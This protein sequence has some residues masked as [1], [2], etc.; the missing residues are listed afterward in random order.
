[1]LVAS[2]LCLAAASA[3]LALVVANG[4]LPSAV[5]NAVF[6]VNESWIGSAAWA[7]DTAAVLSRLASPVPDT[8]LMVAL[9]LGFA[10]S[11]RY[12]VAG[13]LAVSGIAGVLITEVTKSSVGRQRPPGAGLYAQDLE[14]S[15]PSGHA[16]SGIYVFGAIAVVLTLYGLAGRP[17]LRYAGYAVLVFGVVVGCSRIVLSVHWVSDTI[18]GW[19]IGSAVLLLAA[20]TVR[21]DDAILASPPPTSGSLPVGRLESDKPDSLHD[22]R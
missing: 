8:V 21:P 3:V 22:C 15:F 17:P 9:V 11:R 6:D 16:S 1:M 2:A 10:L 18:A 20:A 19:L 13:F 4:T 5:D 14:K 7:R 12:R